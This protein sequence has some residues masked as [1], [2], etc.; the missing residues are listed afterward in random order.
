MPVKVVRSMSGVLDRGK[1]TASSRTGSGIV[2]PLLVGC[3]GLTPLRQHQGSNG[4]WVGIAQGCVG[5]TAT[6][7]PTIFCRA[8]SNL[9]ARETPPGILQY[10]CGPNLTQRS[11][12]EDFG[13][14]SDA[15]AGADSH[16]GGVTGANSLPSRSMKLSQ[17]E[18]AFSTFS[19]QEVADSMRRVYTSGQR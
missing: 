1:E 3:S 18:S 19:A 17:V 11:L 14:H 9:L 12:H 13:G 2:G 10:L 8:L 5:H 7:N 16:P 15:V 4:G 6:V